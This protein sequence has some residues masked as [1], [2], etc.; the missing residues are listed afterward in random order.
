MQMSCSNCS[1]GDAHLCPPT[2]LIQ[3]TTRR[4]TPGRRL[5]IAPKPFVRFSYLP[6]ISGLCC[7]PS[8][9]T[10]C[11]TPKRALPLGG[12][13][14]ARCNSTGQSR[15]THADAFKVTHLTDSSFEQGDSK[16][17]TTAP[18]TQTHVFNAPPRTCF[19][20]RA[21]ILVANRSLTLAST[22]I[23]AKGKEQ[24]VF[25]G[26]PVTESQKP[27]PTIVAATPERPR[28]HKRIRRRPQVCTNGR[29][30]SADAH[31]CSV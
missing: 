13:V 28:P 20:L 4:A 8:S 21:R 18:A 22:R 6:S 3:C 9:R 29:R 5:G 19:K 7:A 1:W 17:M 30:W 11:T 16:Q 26:S 25:R 2:P 24:D 12:P 23:S 27:T 15:I 31:K 10:R 14:T